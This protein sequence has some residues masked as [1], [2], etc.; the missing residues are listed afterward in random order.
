[1]TQREVPKGGVPDKGPVL[2]KKEEAER[3]LFIE[4]QIS[5]VYFFNIRQEQEKGN[6][7]SIIQRPDPEDP[8]AVE[9]GKIS[10]LSFGIQ[11]TAG[12]QVAGKDKEEVYASPSREKGL[13]AGDAM[14]DHDGNDGNAPEAVQG[15]EIR[16]GG[17]MRKC[18]WGISHFS[19]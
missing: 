6:D 13:T 15:G 1:M 17:R 4:G 5:M 7:E 2:N 14:P 16:F 3:V 8:V 11:E 10:R 9:S 12:D 18:F 19:A